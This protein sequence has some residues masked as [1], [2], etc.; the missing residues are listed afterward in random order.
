MEVMIDCQTCHFPGSSRYSSSSLSD[1]W[2]SLSKR[3]QDQISRSF[4]TSLLIAFAFNEQKGLKLGWFFM[5]RRLLGVHEIHSLKIKNKGFFGFQNK[6]CIIKLPLTPLPRYRRVSTLLNLDAWI[7]QV[8]SNCV[9]KALLLNKVEK[10]KSRSRI[11][12]KYFWTPRLIHRIIWNKLSMKKK[13]LNYR[14]LFA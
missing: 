1:R 2:G 13:P 4:L 6:T 3:D 14:F 9:S 10:W 11:C 12:S 5:S 8:F 7:L